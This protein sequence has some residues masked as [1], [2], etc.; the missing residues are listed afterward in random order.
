[1]RPKSMEMGLTPL[2]KG[3]EIGAVGTGRAGL[4]ENK[5]L[6]PS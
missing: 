6:W 4:N 1:M 5:V 2:A 3:I